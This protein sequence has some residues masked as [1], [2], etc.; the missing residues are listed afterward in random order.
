MHPY[1][2]THLQSE[3]RHGVQE[4]FEKGGRASSHLLQQHHD[5]GVRQLQQTEDVFAQSGVF[6]SCCSLVCMTL[7][8]LVPVILCS[9]VRMTSY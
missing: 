2:V 5:G 8:S 6:C 4:G 9:L 1:L 3:Q 7:C